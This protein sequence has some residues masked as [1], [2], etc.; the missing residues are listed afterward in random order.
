M[1][2]KSY[3]RL[4]YN[5]SADNPARAEVSLTSLFMPR[6]AIE[7]SLKQRI[8]IELQS[9]SPVNAN[10]GD[11]NSTLCVA[12]YDENNFNNPRFTRPNQRMA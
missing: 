10:A 6:Q 4:Y 3:S 9:L 11:L 8:P 5:P 2:D 12:C 7:T 1:L